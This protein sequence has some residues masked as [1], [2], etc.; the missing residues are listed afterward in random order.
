[1][2]NP[3]AAHSTPQSSG[4]SRLFGL[5]GAGRSRQVMWRKTDAS[6]AER[7][8]S[9]RLLTRR[10]P[11][12]VIEHEN[13]LA[14]TARTHH[15][16][17]SAHHR[18]SP[19]RILED[20]RPLPGP[21][22]ATH[23]DV[24]QI[25]GGRFSFWYDFVYFSTPD[26]SDPRTNGRRYEIEYPISRTTA[27]ALGLRDALGWTATAKP[28][29]M[30]TP[31]TRGADQLLRTWTRLGC[32]PSRTAKLLDFGCGAGE[33]VDQFRR[34]GYQA[35]GCDIMLPG[36]PVEPL[37]GM[38]EGG[39]VGQI[40]ASPYR[41]PFADASF[42]V[43]F[44]VTV[45]EH[46]MD[47]DTAL[48]EIRRVLKPDGVSVHLFPPPWKPIETHVFV[49]WAS[50]IQW[51]WWLYLWA[52]LGIR[53][54]FQKGFSAARTARD[55]HRFLK[56]ETNYLS[57][58]EIREHVHRHFGECQFAEEAAFPGRRYEFFMNYPRLLPIYRAWFSET[59]GRVLVCKGVKR[60]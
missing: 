28:T 38:I 44:S 25:G 21:A 4:L 18:P 10:A 49:P 42:D 55:N 35:F 37:R 26:N 7:S 33:R 54:R 52:L 43:V 30:A 58:R 57:K 9:R 29:A 24:R 36:R 22:N 34:M 12:S 13:G 46:V 60:R 59:Y 51:R 15:P 14:F 16:R 39:V 1:M 56:N 48:A 17:L 20:G 45:F 11:L 23:D 19:A 40:A 2:P 50:R 3:T 41:I 31:G 8:P 47:Y 32:T 53:N 6:A 5:L 27:V